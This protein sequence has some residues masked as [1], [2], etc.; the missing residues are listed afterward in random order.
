MKSGVRVSPAESR[1]ILR[2]N[3]FRS[4]KLARFSC[5]ASSWIN[6]SW[7]AISGNAISKVM[8]SLRNMHFQQKKFAKCFVFVLSRV[9]LE[10]FAFL[11]VA[12]PQKTTFKVSKQ[13]A[14]PKKTKK[15]LL[16]KFFYFLEGLAICQHW[17]WEMIVPQTKRHFRNKTGSYR[18][19]FF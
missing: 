14:F 2:K 15:T 4:K 7:E 1:H 9:I 13:T 8:G 5:F 16:V 11:K 3:Y 6:I 10:E 19:V 17:K 12:V 18:K